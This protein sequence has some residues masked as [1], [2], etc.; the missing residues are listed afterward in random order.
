MNL[1]EVTLSSECSE[2]LAWSKSTFSFQSI[3]EAKLSKLKHTVSLKGSSCSTSPPKFV[4][5]LQRTCEVWGVLVQLEHHKHTKCIK[6]YDQGIK[7][8]YA[9]NQ[10]K[11][12]ESKTFSSLRNLQKVCSSKGLVKILASWFSELT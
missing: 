6:E 8:M 5:H 2:S 11:F 12:R 9:I 1:E 4:H 10:S 3:L 7:H